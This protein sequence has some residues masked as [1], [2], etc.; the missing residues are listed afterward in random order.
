MSTEPQKHK[1]KINFYCS[2][3][4][5][6]CGAKFSSH[7]YYT[8]D[9]PEREW[10][11]FR[12]YADC[13]RCGNFAGQQNWELSHWKQLAENGC[14]GASKPESRKKISDGQLQ[15]PKSSYNSSRYNRIT[16]GSYSATADYY[17]ARPGHYPECESCEYLTDGCG[18]EMKW[19]GKKIQFFVAHRLAVEQG[20]TAPIQKTVAD[21]FAGFAGILSSMIRDIAKRGPVIETPLTRVDKEEGVVVVTYKDDQGVERP[22]LQVEPHPNL[23]YLNDMFTRYIGGLE[24]IGLNPTPKEEEKSFDGFLDDDEDRESLLEFEKQDQQQMAHLL[25]LLGDDDEDDQNEPVKGARLIEHKQE[26]K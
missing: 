14:I 4:D 13:P 23:K 25:S 1:D 15:R 6:G 11:P 17:P 24:K 8:E 22:V 18:T 12:Y 10:L 21:F 19:C 3:G 20:E 26:T 5:L 16:H 7:T 2:K 9:Y